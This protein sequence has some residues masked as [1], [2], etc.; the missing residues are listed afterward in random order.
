MP[1]FQKIKATYNPKAIPTLHNKIKNKSNKIADV[2]KNLTIIAYL[3]RNAHTFHEKKV[4]CRHSL[5]ASMAI[6]AALVVP[7]LLFAW[8]AFISLISTVNAYEKIQH[9]LS[10]MAVKLSVEAGKEEEIPAGTWMQRTWYELEGIDGLESGGVREVSVFDFSDSSVLDGDEWICLSVGYRMKLLEG[11]IP[12]PALRMKNRIYIRAWTGYIPGENPGAGENP[13]ESVYV[14][15]YGHV[16]HEN[17]MCSH[18]KLSIYM[19]DA[20]D[21]QKYPPC[22]KCV[23]NAAFSGETFYLTESGE[24]YHSRLSCSGLKRSVRCIR[25]T[26]AEADGYAPCQ[27]CAGE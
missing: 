8:I 21:A 26:E 3:K 6:E 20:R 14:A 11:L 18:I 1:F 24:C 17:R 22:V 7:L 19:V 15:D 2:N 16:Y 12:L 23:G 25:R 4:F 9:T 27:R 13:G 10:E 5:D